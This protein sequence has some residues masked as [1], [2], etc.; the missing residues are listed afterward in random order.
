MPLRPVV[1]VEEIS[2]DEAD[3][4]RSALVPQGPFRGQPHWLPR[5][6]VIF[7]AMIGIAGSIWLFRQLSWLIAPVFLGLNLVI[8]FYPIYGALTRRKVP[9]VLAALC[10]ALA[11]LAV[12][13]LVVAC[14]VWAVGTL[15][16]A[17]PGYV[18][19][20][21]ELYGTVLQWLV[22]HGVSTDAVNGFYSNIDPN[23]LISALTGVLGSISGSIG[24][25]TVALTTILMLL[26]DS[27][28]WKQRLGMIEQGHARAIAAIRDFA[29]GTRRYWIVS[30]IFGVIMASLNAIE[31]KILGVPL[32]GVWVVLTFVTTFIPS[33]GFFFAM[34]PPVLVA[35]I[36]NGW[37]NALV[38]M[39]VYF[40]TTWIVQGF[41]Q[42]KFTGNA[43]GVN[44]TTS[45]VSLLF[46][47]WV[48]G[49]LGALIALPATQLVKS[50]VLDADPK[51]RWVSAFIA[52]EPDVTGADPQT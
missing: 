52:A 18:P 23:N 47:A 17:I 43:V 30:M 11:L 41:F 5:L 7:I 16:G 38:L 4:P 31:L 48:F 13:I 40:L 21:Q 42:P 8:A 2:M 45:F 27:T 10:M 14:V 51:S 3:T 15:I 37:K 29:T 28:G 25:A 35:L 34:I 50:L 32:M 22:D 36:A 24:A 44:I 1:V 46:W 39:V 26:I 6:S 9:K 19:R 33:V 49:P 20:V 12:L